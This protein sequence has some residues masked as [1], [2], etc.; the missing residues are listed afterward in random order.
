MLSRLRQVVPAVVERVLGF[1]VERLLVLLLV[2]RAGQLVDEVVVHD[3][4]VA[5]RQPARGEGDRDRRGEGGEYERV[6][7][8]TP[9]G[10]VLQSL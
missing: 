7:I 4:G 10:E 5:Q 6:G 1:E 8:A 3:L 9:L 2:Q